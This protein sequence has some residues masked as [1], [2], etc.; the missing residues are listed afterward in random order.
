M[1]GDQA[2]TQKLDQFLGEVNAGP[3]VPYDWSGNEPD[4]WVPWEFDYSGAPW[5]TQQAVRQIASTVYALSP[6]GEP[7]NDDLGVMSAWYVWAALGLYP[8]TPG[9]GDLVIGSPMFPSA[10]VDLSG[11]KRLE[12]TATGTPDVYVRSTTVAT[13]SGGATSWQRPWIPADI[14]RDGGTLHFVVGPK[15]DKSWGTGAASAPPSYNE[16]ARPL[17]GFTLPSGATQD[18]QNKQSTV[19]LGIESIRTGRRTVYWTATASRGIAV[20]PASGHIAVPASPEGAS[21]RV[22]TTVHVTSATATGG[23]VHFG[24]SE[25]GGSAPIPPV[26]IEVDP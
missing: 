2:A 6:N 24:F 8:L 20:S 14:V 19:T 5:R 23:T 11:G 3:F 4:L 7:G 22:L 1:G 9:T 13:G 10:T 15:P 16:Y 17:V 12:I 21:R 25:P 18:P 26:V